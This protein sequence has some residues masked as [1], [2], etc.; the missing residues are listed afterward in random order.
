MY[1]YRCD[2]ELQ[3]RKVV[4]NGEF[5][6]SLVGLNTNDVAYAQ[7][8]ASDVKITLDGYTVHAEMDVNKKEL[9]VIYVKC[10][11]LN[12][13]ERFTSCPQTVPISFIVKHSYFKN[14]H[15]SL[16]R[17]SSNTISK[18][19]PTYLKSKKRKF[20]R[21]PCPATENL[22][23]DQEHQL[24]AL[25]KMMVCN[26]IAPFLLTGSFGTGKTRV[27]ATAAINFLKRHGNHTRVLICTSHLHSADAYI[28]N[29]FGPMIDNNT[30]PSNVNPVRVRTDDY[31]YS[32]EYGDLFKTI[33]NHQNKYLIKHSRLI[34]TT[35][36]TAPQ[37]IN[38]KMKNFTHIL[39]DEG[40][41]TREPEAIAPLG[42]A[43]NNT[44]IVIAGDHMQV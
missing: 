28:D 12:D 15:I 37:L 32:G 13:Y 3:V 31:I 34:V 41:Q 35:F 27:L 42:L 5:C 19:I 30:L 7:Q 6:I 2:K 33:H 39:I 20:P 16:A 40:A 18:L 21:I 44:K 9:D 11:R 23:L 14:L 25:K 29:Y 43:K 17:I 1:C 24:L 38:L 8:A 36:L 26:N 22:W 4:V 10:K